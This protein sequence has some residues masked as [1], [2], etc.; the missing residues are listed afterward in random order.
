V[1][2]G[3][4]PPATLASKIKERG[5]NVTLTGFVDDIRPFVARIHV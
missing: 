1:I 4:N 3:R 5:L 2:I